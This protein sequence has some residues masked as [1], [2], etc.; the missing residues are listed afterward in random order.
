MLWDGSLLVLKDL[1]ENSQHQN[2]KLGARNSL[3]IQQVFL[4]DHDGM[5]R[6]QTRP[7]E[8]PNEREVSSGMEYPAPLIV[9]P[10]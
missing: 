10:T 2:W 7:L 8:L 4:G 6:R 9:P 5:Q 3:G 1:G